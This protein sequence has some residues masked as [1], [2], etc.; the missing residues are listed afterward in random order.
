MEVIIKRVN[1]HYGKGNVAYFTT[2]FD[3]TT[4]EKHYYVTTNGQ[5]GQNGQKEVTKEEG[6]ELFCQLKAA[7]PLLRSIVLED[8]RDED[9]RYSRYHHYYNIYVKDSFYCSCDSLKEAEEI[10]EYVQELLKK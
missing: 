9:V 5:N 1:V 7:Y 6:N 3:V 8:I 10:Q 2:T 4:D